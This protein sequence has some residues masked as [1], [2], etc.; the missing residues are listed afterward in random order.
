MRIFFC[1]LQ[2]IISSMKAENDFQDL[3]DKLDK[4]KLTIV[5][6][7]EELVRENLPGADQIDG[8]TL[9]DHIP[10]MLTH[11]VLLLK[12]EDLSEMELGKAHGFQRAVLTKISIK[13]VLDEFSFL[14]IV[15]IDHLYPMGGE[16]TTKFVHKFIDVLVRNSVL[17]FINTLRY[18]SRLE[19]HSVLSVT[20]EIK[21]DPSIQPGVQDQQ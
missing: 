19:N 6:D 21:D 7:W 8:I 18:S 13:N 12:G 15:L 14:R 5:K 9:Q 17:Q 16:A 10:D 20:K 1:F 11:L 3:A 4:L 2:T